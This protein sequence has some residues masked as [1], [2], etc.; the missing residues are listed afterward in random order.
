LCAEFLGLG[1]NLVGRLCDTYCDLHECTILVV[2]LVSW[3]R[4]ARDF[5][6]DVDVIKVWTHPPKTLLRVVLSSASVLL[7]LS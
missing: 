1:R 5:F 3:A 6:K 4:A 2:Q 7:S